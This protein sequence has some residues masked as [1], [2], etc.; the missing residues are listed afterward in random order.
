MWPVVCP[1][2]V[3]WERRG[4]PGGIS[5]ERRAPARHWLLGFLKAPDTT[6]EPIQGFAKKGISRNVCGSMNWIF[7]VH[8]K[9]VCVLW[10][11]LWFLRPD[12]GYA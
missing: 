5:W 9:K 4:D 10:F 6:A 12:A 8:Q 3:A 2:V 1:L 11:L 7:F